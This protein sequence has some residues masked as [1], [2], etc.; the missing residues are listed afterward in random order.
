MKY[1][2]YK[3]NGWVDSQIAKRIEYDSTI[4]LLLK[5]DWNSIPP[6][7]GRKNLIAIDKDENLLWIADLASNTPYSSYH[8]VNI[9]D[10]QIQGVCSSFLCKIDSKTGKVIEEIFIK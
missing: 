3:L 5:V 2:E 1:I 9:V 10:G 7:E 8:D 6:K 4:I